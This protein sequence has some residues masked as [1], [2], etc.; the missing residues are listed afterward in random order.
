[1]S[2]PFIE[3]WH[4]LRERRGLS[5]V[6]A[7]NVILLIGGQRLVREDLIDLERLSLAGRLTLEEAEALRLYQ[8]GEPAP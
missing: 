8:E 6:E 7:M 2:D 5:K 4:D 1:M 3:N